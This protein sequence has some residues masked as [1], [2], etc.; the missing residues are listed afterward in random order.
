[1]DLP[2]GNL[3]L[4]EP[5]SLVSSSILI[6]F[7]MILSSF[8][9]AAETA[10]TAVS[11]ARMLAAEKDGN[12]RAKLVNKILLRKD[13]MIGAILL[14]NNVINI[15]ASA[16]TTSVLIGIFGEAG[17][18]YATILMTVL[19]LI[20]VEV[21]PK[22]YAFHN[23][24]NLALL[25]APLAYVVITIFSPITEVIAKI[26]KSTLKLF[27]VDITQQ[28]Q[29]DTHELLRG[30]IEMHRGPEEE[31]QKQRAMLKS[32]LDLA[33]VTVEDV[34]IHRRNVFMLNASDSVEKIIQDVLNS[35]YTRLPLWRD[36]PDNIMGVIHVKWLLRELRNVHNDSS[37]IKIEHIATEPWFIPNSTTL[38]DQLQAFRE[39]GE[40]LAFVVDEYG[41]FMGVVTLEDILEEIVG[42]ID[43]EHDVHVPGVRKQINGTYLINGNVTIRDLNREFEWEL[44]DEQ[45][46]TIAGLVLYEAQRLPEVGQSFQFY[47]F[48]FD[49]M[50][51]QRNQI[52]LLRVTPPVAEI[53]ENAKAE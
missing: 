38:F 45:Y 9:S 53:S 11:P 31:T 5:T 23:A 12:A 7:L 40:H 16:I 34:M 2:D 4:L 49:V 36:D 17:V 52:M 13:R 33:D 24:D 1:M 21:L 14:G 51:R 25:M 48:T 43:D 20:F 50:R 15:L 26:V 3:P 8:F 28:R 44:P 30:A 46:S 22:T 35:P 10:L 29:E 32:V 6:L 47:N 42:D 41:S 39:R 27:G 18:I 19:I 37:R